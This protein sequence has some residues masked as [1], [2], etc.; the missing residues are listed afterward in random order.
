M[1]TLFSNHI[2]FCL[3]GEEI[4]SELSLHL[5]FNI[6]MQLSLIMPH[7]GNSIPQLNQIWKF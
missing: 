5:Q 4:S 6:V 3:C 2:F 7:Y 1:A